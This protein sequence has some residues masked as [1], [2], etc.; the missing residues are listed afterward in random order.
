MIHKG[1]QT[2]FQLREHLVETQLGVNACFQE[3][4]EPAVS[5]PDIC[6]VQ[7]V[8]FGKTETFVAL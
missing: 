7:N 6:R 8:T 1:L 5:T 4:G 3:M 2:Y